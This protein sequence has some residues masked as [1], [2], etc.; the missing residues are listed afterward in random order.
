MDIRDIEVKSNELCE[1][2]LTAAAGEE[3]WHDDEGSTYTIIANSAT[4]ENGGPS[5]DETFTICCFNNDVMRFLTKLRLVSKDGRDYT[6]T[7]QPPPID[8]NRLSG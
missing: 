7:N 6:F 8:V 5:A 1:R 4:P 3:N 2:V